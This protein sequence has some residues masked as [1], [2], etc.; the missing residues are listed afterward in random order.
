L[1][2]RITFNIVRGSSRRPP[3]LVCHCHQVCDRTIRQ[4]IREGATSV[5]EVGDSCGAGTGCG[6][7]QPAIA[8]LLTERAPSPRPERFI[9]QVLPPLALAS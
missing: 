2:L 8:G 6:G 9:L 5:E 1:I 7:C 4:C 3:V